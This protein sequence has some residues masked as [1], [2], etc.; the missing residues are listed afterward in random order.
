MRSCMTVLTLLALPAVL[1]GGDDAPPRLH[2]YLPRN[3]VVGPGPIRLG[4][5]SVIRSEDAALAKKAAEVTLGRSPWAAERIVIGR[6]TVLSRLACSG[7]PA[8]AVRLTG[9]EAVTV[10]GRQTLLA[11]RSLVACA[12][13]YLKAHPPGGGAA[14]WRL[15]REPD[16][17]VLASAPET[18]LKASLAGDAPSRHVKVTV[19]VV[20][21]ERELASRDLLFRLLYPRRQA[22]L[23]RDVA[24]GEELTRENAKVETVLEETPRRKPWAAPFGLVAATAIRAGTVL[25]AGLIRP[26]RSAVIVQR[27]QTVVMKIAGVGFTIVGRGQ[28]LQDG[29]AG[30]FIKVRNVDSRRVIVARVTHEGT[31]E[32][33]IEESKP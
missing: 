14:G 4:S 10:A 21:G 30:D 16:D 28:A 32:P 11:A 3:A 1:A 8:R 20:A 7:V 26:P 17:V 27:G 29:R 13:A 33:V 6:R 31:V 23:T 24:E 19:A 22:V 25:R 18:E 12:E 9:A 15:L 2:V 5:V